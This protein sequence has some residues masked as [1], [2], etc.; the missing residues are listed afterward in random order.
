MRSGLL[1][2]DLKDHLFCP[3]RG[4]RDSRQYEVND[5]TPTTS[6]HVDS[7][8]A[9]RIRDSQ[10]RCTEFMDCMQI[11]AYDGHDCEQHHRAIYDAMDAALTQCDLCIREY[12]IAKANFLTNLEVDY[13]I[14]EIA[15]FAAI[16]SRQD[17][18]RIVRGLDTAGALLRDL[19]KDRQNTSSLHHDQVLAMHE[20]M[21]SPSFSG[22]EESLKDHFDEVFKLIQGSKSFKVDEYLAGV[23]SF[24]FG[25]DEWR[26]EW[27]TRTIAN[28]PRSPTD[29]EWKHAMKDIIQQH[30]LLAATNTGTIGRFWQA[31]KVITPK[32]SGQQIANDLLDLQPN[33]CTKA[34]DHLAVKETPLLDI[35]ETL[36]TIL[37]KAHDAFWQAMQ[38]RS[39]ISSSTIAEQI[40][41]SP[42]FQQVLMKSTAQDAKIEEL[43]L[44]HWMLSLLSSL[45]PA[46][47]VALC[48]TLIYQLFLRVE[49]QSLSSP[50]RTVC[51]EIA[52]T[53]IKKTLLSFSTDDT[54]RYSVARVVLSDLLIL[55]AQRIG[56][57]LA[58]SE[59]PASEVRQK[60]IRDDVLTILRNAIAL[61]CQ[62]LRT[63]FETL[64]K[65]GAKKQEL[66]SYSPE[67]W[68][69]AIHNLA[70]GDVDLSSA[71]IRGLR[72]VPG[73]EAL[74]S[75]KDDPLA[76]EKSMFNKVFKDITGMQ[77]RI[78]E[79]LSEFPNAHLTDMLGAPDTSMGIVA[80]LLS[81]DD[82]ISQGA[83]DIVKTWSQESERRDALRKLIQKFPVT[84]MNGLSWATRRISDLQTFSPVSRLLSM[85]RDLLEVLTDTQRGILRT[86]VK[87]RDAQAHQSYWQYQW[88]CLSVV[89][90]KMEQWAKEVN[91]TKRMAKVC[92]DT[93]QYAGELLQQYDLWSGALV[94]AR[95]ENGK[96]IPERLLYCSEPAIG[97]PVRTLD[98]MV[99]WLRLRDEYLL[100]KQVTLV[101][102]LLGRLRAAGINIK[103]EGLNYVE[104][105]ASDGKGAPKS[106]LEP[107]QKASLIQALEKY[108]GKSIAREISKKKQSQLSFLSGTGTVSSGSSRGQ[109][110]ASGSL[111]E[112]SS[113]NVT[114]DDD[115]VEISSQRSYAPKANEISNRKLLPWQNLAERNKRFEPGR[116][117]PLASST[118]KQ[119]ED[120]KRLAESRAFIEKRKQ[121]K[122]ASEL[123]KQE[124]IAKLH[125]SL[126]IGQQTRGQGSGLAALGVKGKDHNLQGENILISSSSESDSDDE[127]DR[128]MFGSKVKTVNNISRPSIPAPVVPTKKVKQRRSHKDIRARLSPD[129]SALHKTILGWDFFFQSD[130]PPDSTKSDYTLVTNSFRTIEDYQRTFEPLLI[131]E[132]WQSFRAAREDG[133]FKPFEIKVSNTL[134]VD[135]F[136]EINSA[137]PLSAKKE[138][139]PDVGVADVVLLSTGKNPH[140]DTGEK[141]CL[142][143][144]KEVSIKKGERVISYRVNSAGNSLRPFL[145]EK[146]VVYGVTLLSLTPLEREY[147]ALRALQYYDLSEEV[148]RA[149]PSPLPPY[150]ETEI[151]PFVR[152]YDVNQAQ[153]KAIR[154]A[155]D[156]DAFTLIQ[157]PP[158]S[159]KTKTIVAIVGSMMTALAK[160]SVPS[161]NGVTAV[162]PPPSSKKILVCAPSNAAVD[163][164]VMRFKAGVKLMTG[165]TEE[166]SVVRLGRSDAINI[167]V[168]DVTLEELVN[169]KL[170]LNGPKDREDVGAVIQEH[171]ATCAQFNAVRERIFEARNKGQT[172]KSEDESL[173][174]G[175]GRKKRNLSNKID[176]LKEQQNTATRD[177]DIQRKK[178]QQM[179]LDNAHILCATLSGS[180]HEI[181]QGLNVEF[182]TVIIDEAA[183][184]I[185]LSALI[186]LKYGCSKCIL[187]GDPKQ[188]PPTVLSREAAKFQYQQSL[189][190]RMEKNHP[191]DVHLLDTQYRMH[192]EISLYP[193]RAF[194]DG[195][196]KDGQGMAQLRKRP[197]HRSQLLGPY[198]FFDVD[199]MSASE[200]KGHSL[201]NY[202]ELNVAMQ[203]YERLITDVPQ[204]DFDGKVGIITPYKGQ[205][206]L[207][208]ERFT[209]RYGNSILSTVEFATTDSFQGRESEVIIFSCVRAS[210][211]GI[212]FL[213]DVRRM[214]VGL[215][216]AKCSLWVLGN[217]QSLIQGEFWRGLVNDAQGR[218]L[219]TK[220][221]IL[222]L[223]Q[224]PLL[225][226]D[227][228]KDDI[229][230]RDSDTGSSHSSRPTSSGS[231]VPPQV[232]SNV[233]VPAKVT[234]QVTAPPKVK[235]QI[236]VPKKGVAQIT[237]TAKI[238]PQSTTS[239]QAASQVPAP[240]AK[241]D[242]HPTRKDPSSK[243][244][245]STQPPRS[246][247]SNGSVTAT[248]KAASRADRIKPMESPMNVSDHSAG[249]HRQSTHIFCHVCGSDDHL[250][251]N[252]DNLAAQ[253][254]QKGSCHRCKEPG[255]NA[256]FCDAPRCME[257]G[258]L[259]HKAHACRVP[260]EKRLGIRD[261][262][263]VRKQEADYVQQRE[264]F[265]A[266]RVEKQLGTHGATVP[267]VKTSTVVTGGN[268]TDP[269]RKRQASPDEQ[270]PREAKT[271]KLSGGETTWQQS[272]TPWEPKAMKKPMDAPALDALNDRNRSLTP[273]AGSARPYPT[274]NGSNNNPPPRPNG[275]VAPAPQMRRKKPADDDIFMK[276]K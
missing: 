128:K 69:A 60:K 254:A 237:A 239:A 9:K 262:E 176:D 19:P 185:E 68:N 107:A 180:G 216:R 70:P 152:N 160:A 219:Y 124:T 145:N 93:M 40:F 213:Q 99:K 220:G 47:K 155:M 263:E 12:Y 181:F 120:A 127:E 193:S 45:K 162:P 77:A 276:R 116:S 102:T 264:K 251:Q 80:A 236:T 258:D 253:S 48:Q 238:K 2:R 240:P 87:P 194:Y 111:Q 140:L 23:I 72:D 246:A 16:I 257:C 14:E 138:D 130:F 79:T 112:V 90:R 78:F 125:G 113:G 188:L 244:P 184:S 269:K 201:L 156:N 234:S 200:T 142:A 51:F 232:V 158:G 94:K 166:L 190:A 172:V 229:E 126:G 65:P 43:P 25:T 44:F 59:L 33:L 222:S 30:L 186:P 39:S 147:A 74:R 57:L 105:I 217:S 50:A 67:I 204:Y 24:L 37:V 270:F 28:I 259:G 249:R 154:S 73:L 36:N 248:N 92:Q 98:S 157:G 170:S 174:E 261:R 228:M 151:M 189:F 49:N 4:E 218:N 203:L 1:Q 187:V 255:H 241:K 161:R 52:V 265:R 115:V 242:Q 169:A 62:S 22:S 230:M 133:S 7:E 197:W 211:K 35:V 121:D 58:P 199:G 56:G 8:R 31:M 223:L 267:V 198:R 76:Q 212:G 173:L 15:K 153:A 135:S 41:G 175:L 129:L 110:P 143:R 144:V 117:A 192:P 266:R 82:A 163:E 179:I 26:R 86:A 20:A 18:Q 32:L 168:R 272:A 17:I 164:L 171:I 196:L 205:L 191:G 136:F 11:L 243:A 123:R 88:S 214:N 75:V 38:S 96:D 46:S 95:P 159:G 224:R 89:F 83:I 221:D 85:G 55:I 81:A 21:I 114:S 131:L 183:Q 34:L 29:L 106:K 165:K 10:V 260:R 208:R 235:P 134:T 268:N 226:Q 149:K 150:S 42:G 271:T 91:D 245:S 146:A 97:N 231:S 61:E 182:E 206:R 141:Y 64:A 103:T 256:M 100:D 275:K 63:D 53:I 225:T 132:G 66:S 109:S 209:N 274:P 177:A 108:Y 215:T 233:P 195:R 137:M 119:H 101:I 178:V 207:L 250:T 5:T 84:T 247:N 13:E 210:T 27:A 227:M 6:D 202:A 139:R 167:N 273:T 118:F 122:A 252:C 104:L 148:I 3:R 54:I 71:I